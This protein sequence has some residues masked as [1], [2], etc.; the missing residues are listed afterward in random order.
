[1]KTKIELGILLLIF[2]LSSYLIYTF[3]D[4]ETENIVTNEEI[5]FKEEYEKLNGK[6]NNYI[7]KNY[8]EIEVIE[9]SNVEYKDANEII[10]ILKNGTGI[11]YFGFPE[12]PWCRNLIPV[13]VNK[14]SEYNTP[15]YYYNALNIRDTKHLD[16]NNNIIVD[17]EGTKEYYEIVS[18]LSDFLGDYEGL[19][20]NTIKRLY[21]PTVVF[22][23]NGKIIDVH[24]GTVDSQTDPYKSLTEEQVQELSSILENGIVRTLGIVCDEGC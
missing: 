10:D 19:N 7:K 4:S 8:Q 14:L 9:N 21:F 6:Y 20:D 22:V 5:R 17:K 11:I 1:M 2:L 18:L 3:V 13:L 12:C 15:F 23:K 24:I 16:E